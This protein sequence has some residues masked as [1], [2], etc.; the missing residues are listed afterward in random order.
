[1]R[2]AANLLTATFLMLAACDRNADSP[3]QPELADMTPQAV[4]QKA[5][6]SHA[7]V[8]TFPP[9]LREVGSS[10]LVRTDRGISYKLTTS[11]LEPGTATTLW[12]AVFNRPENCLTTP[13]GEPD[14]FRSEPMPDVMYAAGNVIGGSGKATFA[15]HRNADDNSGSIF[16]PLGVPAPGLVDP[17]RAEIHLLVHTH[18]PVVPE[19]MP[20][21][22]Q[23]FNGGCQHPGPPFPDPLPPEYG[24]MGPNT[25]ATIQFSIHR[26]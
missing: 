23:T 26:P 21:M 24:A 6:R 1:M 22:I 2:L 11:E 14:L 10:Q 12:L 25:C 19:F 9:E 20:D 3:V 4:M 16:A 15:A 17:R 5:D 18:G 13:C 7:P 8:L